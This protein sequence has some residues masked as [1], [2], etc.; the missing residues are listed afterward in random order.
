MTIYEAISKILADVEAISKE[1]RNIQQGFMFRGI[2]DVMNSLHPLLAKHGVFV[3]PEVLEMQRE[4]RQTAKGGTL[5][6]SILKVKYTFASSDGS[7]VSAIVIGEGM[8]SG[9]K[10]SN[11]A[12]A[13]AMKYALLQVFC[14]PTEDTVDPD[15]ESHSI[16]GKIDSDLDKI[17]KAKDLEELK[18]IFLEAYKAA[19]SEVRKNDLTVAKDKRKDELMAGASEAFGEPE[20]TA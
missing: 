7:T 8:D 18:K 12:M 6:Y 2:D 4:E 10:A 14:I 19:K 15:S 5:L 11:K 17:A 20:V 1:K 9:D 13:V 3:F 16:A